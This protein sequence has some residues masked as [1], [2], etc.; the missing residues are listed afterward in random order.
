MAMLPKVAIVGYPN[1]GKSTLLNRLS[2]KREA[3]VHEIAGVTRDRKEVLAEWTGRSFILIDTGGVDT[4]DR[5]EMARQ[6]RAQAV[7]ALDEAALI[8]LVVDGSTGIGPGDEDL[9][10]MVRRSRRPAILAVN[11]IDDFGRVD[12]IHEFHALGMGEPVPV[13]ALHG[14]GSG[15]L[16]DIIVGR[17]EE[18]GAML[19]AEEREEIKVAM[20]GRPN[21]G[22][23]SM[24]NRLVGQDRVIVAAE[25]GTTRDTIDT[26]VELE[27]DIY[28]FID[29]AGLRRPGKLEGGIEYYS[30]VRALTAMERAQ[31][32]LILI[33]TT[34]GLTDYDLTIIDE[35]MKRKCAT[36]ILLNKWDLEQLDLKDMQ[37]RLARK[38]TLKP[39]FLATSAR[40]GRGVRNILPLVRHLFELY[41]SRIPTRELN[42]FL[43]EVKTAHPPP[44]IRGRQLKMYYISQPATAPPRIVIQV[45]N[46]G[47]LRKAYATY[48]ENEMRERFG[49]HGCPLVIQFRGKKE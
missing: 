35:A 46:K 26:V 11:K 10:N 28:R 47:L 14:T 8:L 20:V 22:K 15:D 25:P 33:D 24:M 19:E 27:G 4:T 48:L 31:V 44:I 5:R 32:A 39:P 40:T 9:A 38:T 3:V 45:N 23:S 18:S 29:T 17:L 16:L 42:R 6:V 41:T 7:A 34:V 1:V 37:W 12:L 36:A 49:Y 43:Q 13:S 21:A 30:R 2:G